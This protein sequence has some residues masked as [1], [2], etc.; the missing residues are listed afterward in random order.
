MIV[1][2]FKGQGGIYKITNIING[3]CYIGRTSDFYRRSYHYIYDFHNRRGDHINEYMLNSMIKYGIDKF[4]F[5]VIEICSDDVI[6]EREFFWMNYFNSTNRNKGYN[7]RMDESGM[8]V[9]H[10]STRKKISERL[11]REWAEGR[12]SD[13]SD[14][15][16]L[17]WLDQ[18]KR[19]RQSVILSKIKTKYKY[20]V[21]SCGIINKIVYYNE[22][23]QMKLHG[24]LSKFAKYKTNLVYFKN[25]RIERIIIDE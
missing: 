22:L 15:L 24:C 17:S 6:Q 5:V 19:D 11:K 20:H 16:K 10:E 7:L 25:F 8:M 14:K 12:R 18:N 3:K 23:K 13:H 4:T 2:K 9:V 21:I 1:S